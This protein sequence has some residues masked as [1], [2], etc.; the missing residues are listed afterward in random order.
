M[1]KD[2]LVDVV[3]HL[4][5]LGVVGVTELHDGNLLVLTEGLHELTVE[6]LALLLA[7]RELQALVVEGNR[8]ERAV[9]IGEHPVL[10]VGPIGE[11]REEAV[12]ALGGGVVDVRPV[13]VDEDPRIVQTVVGV[14]GDVVAALEHADAEPRGLGQTAGANGTGVSRS[15]DDH[16]VRLRVEALRQAR[17][18]VHRH[19]L[20]L[21]NA[22]RLG[23]DAE[24]RADYSARAV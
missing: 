16:I 24:Y 15:H 21:L 4:G 6:G 7:K 18:N 3:R 11:A 5:Q 17:A 10:V 14:A 1:Q 9:D 13:E 12:H 2:V 22:N 20:S 23:V 8:H 19:S